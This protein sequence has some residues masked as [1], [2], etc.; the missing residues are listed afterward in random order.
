MHVWTTQLAVFDLAAGSVAALT[1]DVAN[2]EAVTV[3]PTR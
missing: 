3:C 2:N 1:S